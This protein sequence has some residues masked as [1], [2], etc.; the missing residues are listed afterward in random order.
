MQVLLVCPG[1]L[2]VGW[3]GVAGPGSPP[4]CQP[5]LAGALVAPWPVL[6]FLA[7]WASGP[8]DLPCPRGGDGERVCQQCA[9]MRHASRPLT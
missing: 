5:L 4:G 3:C 7:W 6:V 2:G 1:D 8:G 9:S